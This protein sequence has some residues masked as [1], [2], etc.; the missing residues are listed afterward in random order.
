MVQRTVASDYQPH[1]SSSMN[2]YGFTL[3]E[4]MVV[5]AIIGI[6]VAIAIPIYNAVTIR[7]EQATI[8]YNLRVLDGAIMMY[9]AK[10]GHYPVS[11][12]ET[13]EDGIEW[14]INSPWREDNSLASFVAEFKPVGGESYAIQGKAYAKQHAQVDIVSN[15]AFIVL[16][17]GKMAGGHKAQNHREDYFLANLP[18]KEHITIASPGGR[19]FNFRT[20]EQAVFDNDFKIVRGGQWLLNSSGLTVGAGEHRAFVDNANDEYSITANVKLGALDPNYTDGSHYRS[21]SGYGIY[22]ESEMSGD[23]DGRGYILQFDRHFGGFLIRERSRDRE[24]SPEFEYKGVPFSGLTN[25][26]DEFWTKEH[27]IDMIVTKNPSGSIKEK[28]LQVKL[29]NVFIFD[30][31]FDSIVDKENNHTGFRTWHNSKDTEIRDLDIKNL[32][33]NN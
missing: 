5:V 23:N 13:S 30:W 2:C 32:D 25:I 27:K 16:E 24:Y 15:R 9:H 31:D 20:M 28:K 1:N 19:L 10:N 12:T 21:W 6:L 29:N 26:N 11:N 22:I 4:L 3:V 33:Q 18:W 14:I 17:N 8:E 7:A